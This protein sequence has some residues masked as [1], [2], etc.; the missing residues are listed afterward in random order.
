MNVLTQSVILRAD[1]ASNEAE[2]GFRGTVPI[3]AFEVNNTFSVQEE[4]LKTYGRLG[5]SNG[6]AT[7]ILPAPDEIGINFGVDV[8]RF[9]RVYDALNSASTPSTL[10]FT[11]IVSG[12]HQ[13]WPK[14][15]NLPQNARA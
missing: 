8:L 13:L 12:G 5:R 2:R 14:G 11:S 15:M 9:S 3:V 6:P 10:T 7:S 1:L 4:G